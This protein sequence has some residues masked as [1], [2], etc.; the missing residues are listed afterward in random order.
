MGRKSE[1]IITTT[2]E[3]PNWLLILFPRM[4]VI[5]VTGYYTWC[6]L[7]RHCR[8]LHWHF[9][10]VTGA[11]FSPLDIDGSTLVFAHTLTSAQTRCFRQSWTLTITRT[12]CHSRCT[13]SHTARNK[14][15]VKRHIVTLRCLAQLVDVGKQWKVNHREGDIPARRRPKVCF[16]EIPCWKF[17]DQCHLPNIPTK[18]LQPWPQLTPE[19]WEEW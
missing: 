7:R 6:S 4:F 9:Y 1:I 8:C 14:R 5:Q 11:G 17:L 13:S 15:P 3:E 19:I 16:R 2:E 12:D 18:Q 10:W